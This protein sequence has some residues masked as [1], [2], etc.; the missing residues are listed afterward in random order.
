MKRILAVVLALTMLLSLTACQS[1][2]PKDDVTLSP[3]LETTEPTDRTEEKTYGKPLEV[4]MSVRYADQCGTHVRNEIIKEKFNLTFEYVPVN[5][6]D[7]NEKARTWIAMD[8]SPDIL[9]MDLKGSQSN[10]FKT[11]ASQGAFTEFQENWFADRPELKEIY[12]SS[13]TIDY[14]RVD[15]KLYGWPGMNYYRDY[16]DRVD[17]PYWTYRRDWAKAVG[18]YKEDDIYTWE[19]WID[20]IRTVMAEDPGNNGAGNTAGLVMPPWAF[21]HAAALLIGPPATDGNESCSYFKVGDEYVWPAATEEYKKGVKLTYDMYQEGLIYKDNILF[22]S[23]ENVDM[24]VGGLAFA[25]YAHFGSLNSSSENMLKAGLIQ[26]RH[27]IGSAKVLAWDGNMYLTQ[28]A[29]YWGVTT[30][31]HDLEQEKIDRVM[32]MWDWLRTDDG[33]RMRWLGKEGVDFNVTGPD[34]YDVEILWDWD[35]ETQTYINPYQDFKFEEAQ[36]AGSVPSPAPYDDTFRFDEH[37]Q[38]FDVFHSEKVNGIL[39]PYDYDVSFGYAPNKAKYGDFASIVKERFIALLAEPG[40]DV[41]AEWDQFVE[42]MMP[43]VQL[44]LDEINGGQLK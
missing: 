24:F 16:D 17:D 2:A 22:N 35:E 5:W 39:K 9:H 38:V 27:D 19:E 7:W 40:I 13:P 33:I 14:L 42:E 21:P 12:E 28:V 41:E 15:G 44:V 29:D 11:W 25:V 37:K 34:L 8:D 31:R 10:E 23:S 20:L 30:L 36:P 32:D 43:Q 4:S 1:A 18:K 3:S 26:D 6:S